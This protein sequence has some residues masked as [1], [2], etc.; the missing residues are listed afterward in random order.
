M[1]RLASCSLLPG[2][3]GVVLLPSGAAG[4]DEARP[5]ASASRTNIDTTYGRVD[6]DLG[7]AFGA[8]ATFG[9]SAPRAALDL[10][11]R[12]LDT[13]GLFV[14]YEDGLSATSSDPRRVVA[15][16]FELRPLFLARWLSGRELSVAHLDLFIDSLGLEIGA[17]F[18][19]PT[20]AAFS[21][22]PGL[23]ASLGLELPIL[24][25]ASGPWIGV[26]A[27][28]RWS[29][30]ALEGARVTS[31]ADRSLFLALTIAYHEILATHLVDVA[32]V[33]PR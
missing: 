9:P 21:D 22:S 4:S 14:S 26:H 15:A 1:R 30:A 16:G 28:A 29:D 23:Q 20:A 5:D 33:A 27:G 19:Q 13:A 18:E 3:L 25:R 10:R 8:G 7:V 11:F 24:P 2:L 17:F 31:A 32:D 12:Y 6:G